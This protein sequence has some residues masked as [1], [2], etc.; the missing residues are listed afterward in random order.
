MGSKR[1][2]GCGGRFI[3]RMEAK[4][5]S[6]GF[7]F[8]AIYKEMNVGEGFTYAFGRCFATISFK[9]CDGATNVTL[10]FDPE[11]ENPIDLQKKGWQAILENFKKI[12]R[13]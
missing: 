10:T 2:T 8:E 11:T 12:P 4:D 9:E 13:K 5:E 7:D 6:Q 3:A 1:F